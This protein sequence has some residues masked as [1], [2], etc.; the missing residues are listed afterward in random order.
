MVVDYLSLTSVCASKALYPHLVAAV[1][2]VCVVHSFIH[3][4]LITQLIGAKLLEH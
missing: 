4:T 3:Q 2:S 1:F